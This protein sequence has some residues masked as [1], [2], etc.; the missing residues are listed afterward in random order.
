[1]R[2]LSIKD[3]QERL[4][5]IHPDEELI[6]ISWGG[7][8]EDTVVKCAKCGTEYVK[9]GGSFLDK[10][11]VSICKKC[12]PTHDNIKKENWQPPEGYTQIG[13]YNGMHSKVLVRHDECG[14]IWGITP[15]NL[16]LGKGCPKCNKRMSKGEQAIKI[17][18]DNNNVEY[19]WHYP[20][21]INGHSLKVDFYL[22]VLDLY[23][24]YNG[25]QHYESVPFFGGDEKLKKQ[26]YNDNLK[27]SF[28]GSKL[29]I[30]SYLDF[31]KIEDIL[32][33]S[34]TILK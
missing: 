4:N 6:A 30:I 17:W 15:A 14:F 1:M 26:Q 13:E 28:L 7:D 16:K 27:Q 3:F 2:K 10:R 31:D 23:I 20:L 33:S 29:L 9:K 24:E 8:R 18:L 5:V 19:I 12:F 34:T 11:K 22:P 25:E 32:K 21:T